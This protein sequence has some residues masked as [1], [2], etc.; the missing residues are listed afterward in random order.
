MRLQE[1]LLVT[2]RDSSKFNFIPKVYLNHGSFQLSS[3]DYDF[4]IKRKN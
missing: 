3:K 1:S 4:K 2:R